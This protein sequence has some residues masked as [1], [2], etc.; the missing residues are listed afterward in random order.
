[1]QVE[2]DLVPCSIQQEL[3]LRPFPVSN[4]KIGSQNSDDLPLNITERNLAGQEIDGCS[5]RC[6]LGF[7]D[8]QFRLPAFDDGPV[9]VALPFRLIPPSHLEIIFPDDLFRPG[10][11]GILRKLGVASKIDEVLVLPE[12]PG[13]DGIDNTFNQLF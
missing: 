4:I 1:V 5:L 3:V 7:F 11:S 8:E 12:H 6:G 2:E 13:R 10:E 9:I